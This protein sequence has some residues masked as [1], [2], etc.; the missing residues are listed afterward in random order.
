MELGT[1]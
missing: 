1:T